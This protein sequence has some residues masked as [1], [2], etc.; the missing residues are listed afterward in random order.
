MGCPSTGSSVCPVLFVD[1]VVIKVR[2][3]QRKLVERL[4]GPG[5]RRSKVIYATAAGKKLYGS[6]P[7]PSAGPR[8]P[9]CG[10]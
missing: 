5:D 9:R 8:R 7:T 2:D 10:T 3:G 4:A 6:A 1:A